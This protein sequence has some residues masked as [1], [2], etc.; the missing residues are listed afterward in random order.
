MV[1]ETDGARRMRAVD[2]AQFVRN[3]EL[4]SYGPGSNRRELARQ[5][6]LAAVR[7]IAV[8]GAALDRAVEG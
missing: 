5:C 7:G 6:A 8:D 2:E 4:P 3:R 1:P